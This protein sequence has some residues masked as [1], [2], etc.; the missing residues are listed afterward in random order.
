[1]D[2]K[3][4]PRNIWRRWW[5]I[6]LGAGMAGLTAFLVGINTAP[7]YGA[8]A[9]LLV[10]EPPGSSESK[11]SQFLF[12]QR[13]TQ[14][15]SDMI[16][17]HSVLEETIQR[18]D[19]PLEQDDFWSMIDVLS[20]TDS[21]I[22]EVKVE[23][24]EPVRA[25]AIANTLSRVFIEHNV[26]RETRRYIG[27]IANGTEEVESLSKQ[28]TSVQAEL[29]TL[30]GKSTDVEQ[31]SQ[32]LLR[33]ELSNLQSR[34]DYAVD[35]LYT[36]LAEQSRQSNSVF[37][38][39][40]AEPN[41]TAIRPHT[42]QNTILA[43]ILGGL[44]GLGAIFLVEY[45]DDTIKSPD[46]VQQ[47][48]SLP[49]LGTVSAITNTE[50]TSRLVTSDH[51]RDPNSEAFRTLRTNLDYAAVAHSDLHAVLVT[52]PE[53]GD[54]KSTTVAN[55]GIVFAQAGKEVV[56]IDCDLRRPVQHELF[57]LSNQQGLSTLLLNEG[58]YVNGYLQETQVPG[59]RILASGRLPPFPAEFLGSDKLDLLVAK[60]LDEVDIVLI[61]SPPLLSVTDA[62][63]LAPRASG[64]LLVLKARKTKDATL[65]DAVELLQSTEVPVLGVVINMIELGRDSYYDHRYH[66]K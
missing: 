28:I 41:S 10:A 33:A 47:L 9:R 66:D 17:V 36:L 3:Q 63:V 42:M 51:P 34:H 45:L 59:L 60:L 54:G 32:V 53:P 26:E 48:V 46:Q 8:A 43:A 20:E 15:Y 65:V 30:A 44:L 12:E 50:S 29:D 22:I 4:L 7:T 31:S 57:N 18:L 24:S 49:T 14:T 56:I 6:G 39:E 23:D 35:R 2:I 19:L 13:L 1:M 61:D 58:D 38:L 25:A 21:K 40:E 5:L 62:T 52:S 64:C 16:V 11:F 27:P 55:L 37:F